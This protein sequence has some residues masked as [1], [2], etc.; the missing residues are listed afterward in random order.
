MGISLGQVIRNAIEGERAAAAAYRM[1]A[2]GEHEFGVRELFS[3]LAEQEEN[4]ALE[5]T[6]FGIELTDGRIPESVDFKVDG[7]ETIA[8]WQQFT[9]LPLET[10]MEA[11]IDAEVSAE[12]Y[13]TAVAESLEGKG[14]DFFY[15]LAA[16]EVAHAD[17]LRMMLNSMR[18]G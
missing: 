9:A 14:K 5:I 3:Q 18:N 12:M 1:M 17:R 6:E 11:A 10:A 4:H 8:D 13:Y 2:S 16:T 15:K 7:I